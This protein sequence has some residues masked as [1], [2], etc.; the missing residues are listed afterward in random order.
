MNDVM[1]REEIGRKIERLDQRQFFFHL[2]NGPR[3]CPLGIA[4]LQPLGRQPR[5]T[6]LGRFIVC[7]L[8]RV[9]IAEF[10][11]AKA[12]SGR[13]L[14]RAAQGRRVTG[15]QAFHVSFGLEAFFSVG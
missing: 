9:I 1:H 6:V 10:G 4:D 11:Q 5:Q 12:G 13:D 8:V 15:E 7:D 3:G 14:C 2:R